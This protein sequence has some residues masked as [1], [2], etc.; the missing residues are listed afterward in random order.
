MAAEKRDRGGG[1]ASASEKDE[2][3]EA[4]HTTA[5][6]RVRLDAEGSLPADVAKAMSA[7]EL[8][9]VC[10]AAGKEFGGITIVGDRAYL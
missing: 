3:A 2:K 8:E 10:K 4:V 1:K 5:R 7:E 6:S 9:A